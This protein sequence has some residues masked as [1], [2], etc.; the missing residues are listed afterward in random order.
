MLANLGV[1][2]CLKRVQRVCPRNMVLIVK[3]V[4][5]FASICVCDFDTEVVRF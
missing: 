4:H 1:S 2:T 5:L 3:H